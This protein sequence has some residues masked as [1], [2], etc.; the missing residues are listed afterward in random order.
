MGEML[1]RL[2]PKERDFFPTFDRISDCLSDVIVELLGSLDGKTNKLES[3]E[4]TQELEARANRIV[5]ESIDDLH[6]T[7]VTPFDRSHIFKFL[8]LNGKIINS[9]RLLIEKLNYYNIQD[10]PLESMEIVVK[11]GKSCALIRKMVGQIKKIKNPAETLKT[12]VSIYELIAENNLLAFQASK[13]LFLNE[14]DVMRLIKIKEIN[15]D[16]ISITTYFEAIS[17][18]IEEIILEYA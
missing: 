7:F 17:F 18:L 15:T 4:R 1:Q 13:D 2:F 6:S 9:A 5:R 12:C 8:I 3:L 10:L 14:T 11:C 16:L